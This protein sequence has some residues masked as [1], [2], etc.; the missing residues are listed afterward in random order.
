MA[1]RK[2]TATVWLRDK[3]TGERQLARR[4][5]SVRSQSHPG[6]AIHGVCLIDT[7]EFTVLQVTPDRKLYHR[8]WEFVQ[9][10]SA[11]A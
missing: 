11:E 10:R 9:T 1:R 5:W 4:L 2:K 3:H 7:D 8:R 6:W